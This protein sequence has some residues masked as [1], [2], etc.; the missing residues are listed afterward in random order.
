MHK[1]SQHNF[2]QSNDPR[3]RI[4]RNT[5]CGKRKTPIVCRE[6][7]KRNEKER[8]YWNV[9]EF[10]RISGID[11]NLQ[12]KSKENYKLRISGSRN[13]HQLESICEFISI[14][15]YLYEDIYI[16]KNPERKYLIDILKGLNNLFLT[17]FNL[18]FNYWFLLL[19]VCW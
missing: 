5:M 18:D 4:S 6:R 3:W 9:F 2:E 11:V 1:Y 14:M 16:K 10:G 7:I 17:F 15:I 19:Y 12:G 8:I 13:K